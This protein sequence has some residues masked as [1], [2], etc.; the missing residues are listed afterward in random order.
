[1]GPFSEEKKQGA[2]AWSPTSYARY[3]A[4]VATYKCS[5]NLEMHNVKKESSSPL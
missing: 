3:D 1:M 2:P 5:G 4:E